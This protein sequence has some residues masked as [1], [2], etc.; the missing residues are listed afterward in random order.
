MSPL[1]PDC[2]DESGMT[3]VDTAGQWTVRPCSVCNSASFKLWRDGHYEPD[4]DCPS[5]REH[6]KPRRAT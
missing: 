1:C 6:R 2:R 5:C 3:I 4:H